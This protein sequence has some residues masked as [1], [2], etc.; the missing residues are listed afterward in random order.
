MTDQEQ[1][2]ALH[3]QLDTETDPR[4][5]EALLS[6]LGYLTDHAVRRARSV[7]DVERR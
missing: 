2:R 1:L 6:A 3:A 7:P 4:R 5:R